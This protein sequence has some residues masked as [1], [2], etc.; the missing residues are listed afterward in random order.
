MQW[1]WRE[2]FTSDV[3]ID[4]QIEA[5]DNS[6]KPSGKLIAVQVKGGSSYFRGT[7]T[8]IPFY[9][10]DEHMR[11]WDGHS[12]PVIVILHNPESGQTV[13]QWASVNTAQP[14][15]KGWRIDIPRTKTFEAGA[16]GELQDHVWSDDAIGLRRRFALDRPI[17][18]AIEGHDAYVTIDIWINKSLSYRGIEI[19]L[20][21][22]DK[23]EPDYEIPML[24]TSQYSIGEIMY[25]FLPWLNYDY[26]EAPEEHAGEIETHILAATL[27]EAAKGFLAAEQF[28]NNPPGPDEK[29]YYTGND[30]DEPYDDLDDHN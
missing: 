9:V 24:A 29:E 15:D 10:D 21:D 11:Y 7:E 12:L 20:D 23:K 30:S 27:S 14:T 18:E 17:M 5:V 6:G 25:H 2:Q 26:H 4:A 22:P 16:A 8:T 3:G 13:W 28:F 1:I 19:R